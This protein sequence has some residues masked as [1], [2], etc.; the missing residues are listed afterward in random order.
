MTELM[1]KNEMEQVLSLFILKFLQGSIVCCV[2][3]TN[4]FL[5]KFSLFYDIYQRI[6]PNKIKIQ[7]IF[8]FM[9]FN[10]TEGNCPVCL[11]LYLK[12]V[13]TESQTQGALRGR[14]YFSLFPS[15]IVGL[16]CTFLIIFVYLQKN[17]QK[18]ME[19]TK[20]YTSFGIFI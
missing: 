7:T 18:I 15:V 17:H 10:I 13:P 6:K 16:Q 3:T 8:M 4:F 2:D 14:K 20:T 1:V 11:S 19:N 12:C 5:K 9:V